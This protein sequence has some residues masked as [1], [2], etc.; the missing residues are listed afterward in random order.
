MYP[1]ESGRQ[2]GP[3]T[4]TELRYGSR[5]ES[6]A[7]RDGY[8]WPGDDRAAPDVPTPSR[9][10]QD[11]SSGA[12]STF[13]GRAVPKGGCGGEVDRTLDGPD[14]YMTAFRAANEMEMD[15][16]HTT[17]R[18]PKVK[19]A[20]KTWSVCMKDKGYDLPA[21]VFAASDRLHLPDVRP[22]PKPGDKE[23]KVAVA[24]ARCVDRSRVAVVW[25]ALEIAYQR[26]AI[27]QDPPK[28]SGIQAVYQRR[29]RSVDRV[30]AAHH[31]A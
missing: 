23:I 7:A 19:A 16:F 28:W 31:L 8:W 13:K 5:D 3:A 22:R 25:N 29:F 2:R 26:R 12:V 9:A 30:L 24:D 18:D 27:A 15:S 17:R 14:A 6:R 20:E 1:Q 10:E 21:D 11:V 4:I